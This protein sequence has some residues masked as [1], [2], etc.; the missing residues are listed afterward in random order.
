MSIDPHARQILNRYGIE[1]VRAKYIKEIAVTGDTEEELNKQIAFGND[2]VRMRDVAQWLGDTAKKSSRWTKVGAV[3]SLISIAIAVLI[4][5][6]ALKT[7]SYT[8]KNYAAQHRPQLRTGELY[9]PKD[10]PDSFIVTVL[11]R[12]D[13]EATNISLNFA[14]VDLRSRKVTPLTGEVWPHLRP[15]GI[16]RVKIKLSNADIA[17]NSSQFI[18][19]C[20][21]YD[22]FTDVKFMPLAQLQRGL[23]YTELFPSRPDAEILAAADFSCVKG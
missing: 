4:L 23:T 20:F 16:D 19:A 18:R 6:I 22:G 2:K 12:G 17:S 7:L 11:N 5:G 3:L 1:V 15:N 10:E 21:I 13:E 14:V 8:S 9:L